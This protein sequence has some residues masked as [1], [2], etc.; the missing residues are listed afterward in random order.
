MSYLPRGHETISEFQ[1]SLLNVPEVDR[2]SGSSRWLDIRANG[3]IKS[4]PISKVHEHLSHK[5]AFILSSCQPHI[6]AMIESGL[7][8]ALH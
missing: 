5:D 1:F 8:I 3:P 6:G 2:V 4:S 7:T